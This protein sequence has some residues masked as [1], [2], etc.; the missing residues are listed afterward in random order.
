MELSVRIYSTTLPGEYRENQA[1]KQFQP[2]RKDILC[3]RKN[4]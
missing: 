2:E 1:I 4:N 3:E